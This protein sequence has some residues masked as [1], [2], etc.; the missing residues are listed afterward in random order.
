VHQVACG[1][2]AQSP[3]DSAQRATDQRTHRAGRHEADAC[4]DGRAAHCAATRQRGPGLALRFFGFQRRLC[5]GIRV[6]DG[7]PWPGRAC[8]ARSSSRAAL[9][10]AD[11]IDGLIG[12]LYGS[13]RARGGPIDFKNYS[14]YKYLMYTRQEHSTGAHAPFGA[15]TLQESTMKKTR[16][17]LRLMRARLR[18]RF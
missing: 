5:R 3:G 8:S 15:R 1:G 16:S 2:S 17:S 11:E 6:W 14:L 4:P 18:H 12:A 13:D 10:E 9:F 7:I